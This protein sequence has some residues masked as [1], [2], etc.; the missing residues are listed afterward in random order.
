VTTFTLHCLR[1]FLHHL[2]E[3]RQKHQDETIR[4]F[5]PL[6]GPGLCLFHIEHYQIV[7]VVIALCQE[8][9]LIDGDAGTTGSQVRSRLEARDGLEIITPPNELRKDEATR[10]KFITMK[11]IVSSSVREAISFQYFFCIL[12]FSRKN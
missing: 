12:I 6:G 1:I 4:S 5:H 7:V 9:V 2:K 3:L 10:K 8:K 11:P